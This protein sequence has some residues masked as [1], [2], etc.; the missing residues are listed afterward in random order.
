M[1]KSNYVVGSTVLLAYIMAILEHA[2]K[3]KDTPLSASFNV[4]ISGHFYS[5]GGV[6][7]INMLPEELDLIVPVSL[8]GSLL[9]QVF[10]KPL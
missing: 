8:M 1:S 3:F 6:I 5:I 7:V 4:A 2:P 10:G 9:Y